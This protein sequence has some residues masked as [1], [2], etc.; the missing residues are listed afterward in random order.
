NYKK[1]LVNPLSS[2]G[3]ITHSSGYYLIRC[4]CR[5][6]ANRKDLPHHNSHQKKSFQNQA[7][8]P[9]VIRDTRRI[10]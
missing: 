6:V 4:T 9:H 7:K 8:Q 2:L 3:T 1:V 10:T 5:I